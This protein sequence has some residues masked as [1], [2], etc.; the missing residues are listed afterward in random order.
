M[1]TDHDETP[2]RDK[3]DAYTSDGR[4][5]PREEVR[6]NAEY[7]SGLRAGLAAALGTQTFDGNRDLYETFGWPENPSEEELFVVGLRNPVGWT[8]IN[9]PALTTWRD[10]PTIVDAAEQDTDT[11]FEAAVDNLS[12]LD[13]WNYCERIDR[14]AGYGEHGVLVLN[15]S[16]TSGPSGLQ[17]EASA[18]AFTEGLD[19]IEGFQVF[20]QVAIDD[21][22]WGAPGSDRWGRPVEYTIDLGEDI[23]GETEDESGTI[24]VHYSRVINVPATRLLDDETKARPR[25]EPVLNNIL[26]IEKILGAATELGYRGADYGLHINLD[27]EKVDTS[28]DAVDMAG[29]EGDLFA[30]GLSQ[31]MKTVG[32]DVERLGGDIQDPSGIIDNELS[33]VSMYTGIPKNELTGN[34]QGEVSG[35]EE[36]KKS[37][38]GMISERREQYATTHIVRSL[39]DRLRELSIL[40]QPTGGSYHVRWPDLHELSEADRAD[41][42]ATRAQAAKQLQSVI[43]GRSGD[44]W[45]TYVESGEFPDRGQDVVGNLDESNPMVRDAFSE[46]FNL[47]RGN[48]E[49]VDLT[50][51]EAAQNNAQTVLDWRS[52]SEKDVDGMT[53]TGWRRA[54]QLASGSELSPADVQDIYAWFARHKPSEGDVPDGTEP[55]EDNGRVSILGWGGET[56]R[57]WVA[58]KR[59]RLVELGELE[60][61]GNARQYSEGDIVQSPQGIGVVVEIRTEPFEGKTGEVDASEDSPTYV[62]GL[63]EERVGVGF[64][65]ASELSE[66]EIETDVD[67]PESDLAEMS[68]NSFLPRLTPLTSNDWAMPKSWRDADK[69]A[70]LIL[71]DAW[72]SMGGQFDCGGGGC[73]MGELKD[74]ELCAAMKDEVLGGWTGW[75]KGG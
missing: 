27:P 34:R 63:Q 30:N 3:R 55:W 33:M 10:N 20:P 14:L 57:D 15:L 42:Q 4:H 31:V 35:S 69:P 74:E 47:P 2:T 11:D 6:A 51:P 29:E 56:M 54:R 66:G 25:H 65:R 21:I 62:V 53:E 45:E 16:D 28:S 26:D 67:N 22:D 37:Y 19:D 1:S 60:P 8:V 50:P 46:S 5:I 17:T 61:V 44:D 32:A 48:V 18:D 73:C 68:A 38:F 49:D 23:N 72:A 13:A 41:I 52:D 58:G 75:R 24:T 12:Q 71:L 59:K 40:P 43:P 9:K 39:V 70:R 64:Y 7:A 36:D